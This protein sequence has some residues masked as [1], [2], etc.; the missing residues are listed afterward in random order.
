MEDQKEPYDFDGALGREQL[1]SRGSGGG[2]DEE[3]IQRAR[4]EFYRVEEAERLRSDTLQIKYILVS[5]YEDPQ[6]GWQ[7][8]G[9]RL[10]YNMIIGL[11]THCTKSQNTELMK[12]LVALSKS[13]DFKE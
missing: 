4:A 3:A 12:A 2:L 6:T 1:S 13:S 9:Q 8:Q 11:I 10:M 7:V 5:A